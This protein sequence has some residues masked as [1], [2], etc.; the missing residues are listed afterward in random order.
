VQREREMRGGES[1]ESAEKAGMR[2]MTLDVS[3]VSR[4]LCCFRCVTRNESYSYL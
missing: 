2:N 4:H 1:A 3:P